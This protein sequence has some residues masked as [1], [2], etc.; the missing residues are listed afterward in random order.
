M[1]LEKAA[2]FFSDWAKAQN[3]NNTKVEFNQE[4]KRTPLFFVEVEKD[5]DKAVL[6]YG[7]L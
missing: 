1:L 5:C 3:L 2:K 7:I 4:K 6:C